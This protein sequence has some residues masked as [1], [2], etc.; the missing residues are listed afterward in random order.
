MSFRFQMRNV[1]ILIAGMFFGAVGVWALSHG[2][3]P[4]Q[5]D[6][7]VKSRAVARSEHW[8]PVESMHLYLCAF[9][10]AK[11][12]PEFQ[13]E[14]HHFCSPQGKD[15][16]QC[17]IYDSKG[18]AA[19]LLGVEYIITDAAYQKLPAAEKKFWHPHAYEIVSGQLIAPDLPKMG[20]DVFPGLVNTWGKTWHTW[21]DPSAEFPL[22]EPLLMWSANGDGQIADKLIAHR[23]GQFDIKTSDIRQRR[24]FMGF[25]VPQLPLPKSVDDVGRRWTPDGPDEPAPISRTKTPDRRATTPVKSPIAAVKQISLTVPASPGKPTVLL[26]VKGAFCPLCMAQLSEM[27]AKLAG[28]NLSVSVISASKEEDFKAFPSVSFT[29]VADPDLKLFR[30]YGAY[31]REAK[32][33]TI[34]FDAEGKEVFRNVGAAPMMDAGAIIKSL[35]LNDA[36]ARPE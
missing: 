21:P 34:A 12:N 26:F 28:Q 14:A 11:K 22:G 2:G 8:I 20:D 33:A 19:K 13:V 15:L 10:V 32:H 27:A 25:A 9:H 3:S 35:K 16:H 4:A 30:K 17:V 5:A 31:E 24:K 29:L 18:P 23:D 1:L 36:G 6:D 7:A